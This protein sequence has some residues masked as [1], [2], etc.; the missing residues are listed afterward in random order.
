MQA[1]WIL[2]VGL[3]LFQMKKKN[4]HA[5]QPDLIKMNFGKDMK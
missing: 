2:N 5:T 4:R 1:V 3:Y